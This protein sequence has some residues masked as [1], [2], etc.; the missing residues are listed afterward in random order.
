M[1]ICFYLLKNYEKSIE[2]ASESLKVKK[3]LKG[4]YRRG[5]AYAAL[6]QY[7]NAAEDLK[8]AVKMDTSDPNDI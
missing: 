7:D 8:S 2:K 3:T 6:L 4:Y 5:K 1:S